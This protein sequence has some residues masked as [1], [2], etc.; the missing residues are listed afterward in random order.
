VRN[1]SVEKGPHGFSIFAD[2]KQLQVRYT[3]DLAQDLQAQYSIDIQKEIVSAFVANSDLTEE[4]AQEVLRLVKAYP[5]RAT[6]AE[7]Y[8]AIDSERTYQMDMANAAYGDP[9]NDGKKHLEEFVLYMDDYM[10]EL[11]T[12]LS[13]TWG[14]KAYEN[15]LHTLRKVLA[16][17]VSAMEI[18][19]AP[20]RVVPTKHDVGTHIAS[21][22]NDWPQV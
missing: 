10:R 15:G 18:W 13:R 1:I 5:L 17:G 3:A 11:K 7:V 2:G 14:P 6:R 19:G 8:A 22:M 16:I 4:E 21:T 9:S 12:Q 20:K